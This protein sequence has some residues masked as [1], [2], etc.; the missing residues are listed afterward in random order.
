MDI[1]LQQLL[2]LGLVEELAHCFSSELMADLL[3]TEI[4]FPRAY[5]PV[6][7]RPIEFWKAVCDEIDRGRLPSGFQLLFIAA[8]RQFPSNSHFVRF[9]QANTEVL[10]VLPSGLPINVK[11][12]KTILVL[13]ANPTN[14]DQLRLDEEIR[15]IEAGL[16]RSKMRD[17]FILEKKLAVRP[18]DIQRAMLDVTPQIVHFSGHGV[19]EDGLVFQD[20]AGKARL[21]DGQA[22]ATLFEL[23]K[24]QLDCVVLNA[25]F[26]KVQGEAIVQ[27]IPYVVGM[28][29]AIEHSATIDFS[30]GFYDGLG[31]GQS[32]EF[33]YKLGCS[34][35]QL[36]F[37]KLSNHLVPVLLRKSG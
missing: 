18:T 17:R 35:I 15:R 22:L 8:A 4:N 33:S 1:T 28:E 20:D 10:E 14:R 37:P 16:E 19:G 2:Q 12:R 24:D 34:A 29:R 32:V 5:R 7:S 13:A 25:C 11:E 27:H 6:F 31:A 36:N 9:N 30:V 26:S 23:F 3:L 21:I